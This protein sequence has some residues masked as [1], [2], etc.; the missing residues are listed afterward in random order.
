VL[1]EERET[2]N[3]ISEFNH[4]SKF[5]QLFDVAVRDEGVE[6]ICKVLNI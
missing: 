2:S 4:A 3:F 6:E 1:F 5:G